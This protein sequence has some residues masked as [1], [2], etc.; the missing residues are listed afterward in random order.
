LPLVTFAPCADSDQVLA[1]KDLGS[2]DFRCLETDAL[3]FDQNLE[4]RV[5]TACTNRASLLLVPTPG[6]ILVGVVGIWTIDVRPTGAPKNS[7]NV[8]KFGLAPLYR[9]ADV[10]GG[11]KALAGAGGH[12]RVSDGL[13]ELRRE[14]RRLAGSISDVDVRRQASDAPVTSSD[15]EVRA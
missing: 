6:R 14:C 7:E 5:G 15:V 12:E 4:D 3:D 11:D 13:L 1:A 2:S 9:C 10:S 8:E